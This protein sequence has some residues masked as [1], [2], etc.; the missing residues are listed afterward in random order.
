MTPGTKVV[1]VCESLARCERLLIGQHLT[2]EQ[3]DEII[4]AVNS[5]RVSVLACLEPDVLERRARGASI[6]HVGK[7]CPYCH[8]AFDFCCC[9]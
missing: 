4:L 6:A 7:V 2:G 8:K 5:L 3:A 1:K 9:R